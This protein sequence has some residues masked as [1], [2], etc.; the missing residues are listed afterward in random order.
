MES[1]FS[2]D[3]KRDCLRL[4]AAGVR[5]E[6]FASG[7]CRVDGHP[8]TITTV[9]LPLAVWGT[10]AVEDVHGCGERLRAHYG[11]GP[12]GLGLTLLAQTYEGYPFLLLR[13]ILSNHGPR[14][15]I[16]ERLTPFWSNPGDLHLGSGPSVFLK[17]GWQ[18]W[19]YAGLRRADQ[20]DVRPHPLTRPLAA[21]LLYN[22]ATPFP[23][24]PGHFWSE[25]VGVLADVGARR[26][27]VAG[28]V[29]TADQFGAVEASCAPGRT[30]IALHAQC[31]GVELPPGAELASEWAYL[32][33]VSLPAL[34][35]LADYAEATARQMQ[36]RV[37][38]HPPPGWSSWYYFY[39]KVTEADVLS[40]LDRI[41]ALGETLPIDLVQLDQGYE[42]AWGDWLD[43]K[44]EFPHDLGWLAE[45][46]QA[47][48]RVPGLWLSPLL[49][50]EGCRLAHRHPH[51]I[52]RD[53]RGRPVS[54]G[55][56]WKFIGRGLD[57]THPEVRD[58]LQELIDTAVH[59]WGY[60]YLK[61]DFLYAAALPGVRH[62]PTRTRAQALRGALATIREAA[63]DDVFLLGCGC[64]LGPAIGLL[65]CLRIGPD[66]GP[67][68]N[69]QYFGL[70]LGLFRSDPSLPALRNSLRNVLNRSWMHRRWWINDPENLLVRDQDTALTRDE[71]QAQA[72]V[73]GLSG[74]QLVISDDLPRLTPGRR[75]VAAA[76]FPPPS[77]G[78]VLN[79]AQP[80]DL[81]E[82]EMPELYVLRMQKPWE[83]WLV[84]GLFNWSDEPA[85]RMLDLARLGLDPSRPYHAHDFWRHRYYRVE[86]GHLVLRHVPAH[87]SHCL[88]VRPV[89]EEPHL[90]ATTFHIT[91]GGEVVEWECE[92][93]RLRFTLELGRVAEGEVLLWLPAG[94]RQVTRD[95]EAIRPTSRG[96][97]L[98]ALPLRVEKAA[99]V[100]VRL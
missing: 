72:T 32:Q 53:R 88:A 7:T 57:P 75:E 35:P 4:E 34:N 98:W 30:A 62:D 74:G 89:R 46:I 29:S 9:D 47:A 80:L 50:W 96:P 15:I 5:L 92:G 79:G 11:P 56:V 77:R 82:R 40:N 41:Q 60:R 66:T 70:Q 2:Y 1:E 25:L 24:T 94:P 93:A 17:N 10:E 95:G 100:E 99:R 64:P 8:L 12:A 19:S 51:W 48:N 58:Y 97:R 55:L 14:S 45:Q 49:V 42:P 91:Q 21:P 31:D 81:L 68:W 22:A 59:R 76:L 18:S 69:P 78:E 43:R 83:E 37:P 26:A 27:L 23:R 85:D 28:F 3:Y 44:P 38:P 52:L 86:G 73:I 90:V 71:V 61:L 6:G 16:V 39:Q 13:V 36:A 67:H 65:D 33:F 54:G 87:G 84:V 20:R 63:G